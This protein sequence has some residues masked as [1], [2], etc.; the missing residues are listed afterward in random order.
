VSA[1]ST[2]CPRQEAAP[3]YLVNGIVGS[4][5]TLG[6][7]VLPHAPWTFAFALLGEFLFQAGSYC[8]Q[9]GIVFETIGKDNPL[10]ATTFAFLTAATI[11]L[12]PT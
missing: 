7:I 11:S 1:V 2:D 5:F 4:L 3:L 6:L 8:I 9:I 10:A 12:S